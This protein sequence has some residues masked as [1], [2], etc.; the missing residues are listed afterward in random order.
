M[1]EYLLEVLDVD[2]SYGDLLVL[3]DID[4]QVRKGEFCS[5]VGPSGCGKSTLLRLVLG[6]ELPS[7]GSIKVEGKLVSTPDPSR[8]IVYQ[9]YTLFPHL[10][11]LQ[12]VLLGPKLSTG[13][14]SWSEKY[15]TVKDEAVSILSKMRL[16]NHLDKYPHE[17][18][19]GMQQRVAI[20]QALMMKPKI[21]LMDEP[22]GAL[23]P[24]TK[25][26]IHLFVLEL[27]E[28]L[29]MTIFFVTHD[30]SE[31]LFLGT[32]VLVLSQYYT[33][34]RDET[35]PLQRGAKLVCDLPVKKG[36]G[37]TKIREDEEFHTLLNHIRD[38]GFN[39]A[40]LQHIKDFNLT[41][42]DSMRT[43]REGLIRP[44]C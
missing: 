22:F 38:Q 39:P 21:L 43:L 34:D 7:S 11:V 24:G 28:E 6:Q 25:E 23:D 19:G 35:V 14:F 12:N 8:G 9:R 33:D 44:D 10:S 41:H 37:S 3:D 32:R 1:S 18:S 31:A 17:L 2:K 30:L 36:A 27:W 42:P 26:D 16:E 5:V 4:L 29:Q 13:Y 40:H 20:A 15:K